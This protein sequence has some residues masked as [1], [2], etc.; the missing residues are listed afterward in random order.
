MVETH[1]GSS[2]LSRGIPPPA[3]ATAPHGGIIPALAGNTLFTD[4]NTYSMMDHPRSRG[5]YWAENYAPRRFRGSSPLSRGIQIW[6]Y[7]G[8]GKIRIIP[9]LAGNT[10]SDAL[11]L[12]HRPDHPRSRGEYSL[13]IAGGL[14]FSGSSPLSRGIP[15][16][17]TTDTGTVR[18]IPALAGNT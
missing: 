12:A 17:F 1:L 8:D 5:E 9:A 11:P 15:V 3:G 10:R 7:S 4:T 16:M 18:I 14:F 6:V 13:G 2:P